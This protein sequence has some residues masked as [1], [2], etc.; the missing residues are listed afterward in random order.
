M[1]SYGPRDLA[2]DHASDA[3]SPMRRKSSGITLDC[4]STFG[5]RRTSSSETLSS[6][7]AGLP[8]WAA[9]LNPRNRN[10]RPSARQSSSYRY[11][12]SIRSVPGRPRYRSG[13]S[14]RRCV[15]RRCSRA[16]HCLRRT[17]CFA[18]LVPWHEVLGYWLRGLVLD[19]SE[20]SRDE[21]VRSVAH[22]SDASRIF[23]M[24]AR[25]RSCCSMVRLS[26]IPYA[27]R[28][29]TIARIFRSVDLSWRVWR[30][31]CLPKTGWRL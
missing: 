22:C 16:D 19:F 9:V 15:Y 5:S 1:T 18:W 27:A 28:S 31:I 4:G 8:G 23:R 21:I 24:P 6:M 12:R 7:W 29:W 3:L 10:G 25:S 30:L 17:N 2:R 13:S 26:R 11:R 14:G 20:D